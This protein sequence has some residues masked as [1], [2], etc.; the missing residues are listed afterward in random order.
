MELLACTQGTQGTLQIVRWPYELII[1]SI[2]HFE[3]PAT[4]QLVKGLQP[5]ILKQFEK[6]DQFYQILTNV[7]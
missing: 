3:G 5:L 4:D 2:G 1:L 7:F 6:A